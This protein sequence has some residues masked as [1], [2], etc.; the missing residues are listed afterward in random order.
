MATIND[1]N[2]RTALAQIGCLTDNQLDTAAF[3]RALAGQLEA[4]HI[5]A[6]LDQVQS[7]EVTVGQLVLDV[8]GQADE[9]LVGVAKT[10]IGVDGKVQDALSNGYV[11]CA[12]RASFQVVI[13]GEQKKTSLATRFLSADPDVVRRHVI[14]IRRRRVEAMAESTTELAQLVVERLPAMGPEIATFLTE[15]GATW[16]NILP[17]TAGGQP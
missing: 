4:H 8:V 3:S 1:P 2:I 7:V 16:Q 13:A 15:L 14:D 9:Q 6:D 12:N 11:L 17:P 5:A 10:L